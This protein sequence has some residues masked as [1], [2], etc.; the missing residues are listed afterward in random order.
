MRLK[1]FILKNW[2]LFILFLLVSIPVVI[3]AA[4][5]NEYYII[6]PK[7]PEFKNQKIRQR[8]ADNFSL[9]STAVCVDASDSAHSYFV[10]N[11]TKG[12]IE[13]FFDAYYNDPSRFNGL[14]VRTGCCA[15][16][17]CDG[18]SGENCSTCAEDCEPCASPCNGTITDA[19]DGKCYPI[20]VSM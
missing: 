20:V 3:F 14:S 9:S 6:S 8:Q 7:E 1:K 2:Y 15:D 10:G 18:D 17:I 5:T 4:L 13:S 19:R 16:N 11:K 12:E